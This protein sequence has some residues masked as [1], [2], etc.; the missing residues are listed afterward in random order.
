M[1]RTNKSVGIPDA[2]PFLD[3]HER[4]RMQFGS[5][6]TSDFPVILSMMAM[7]Q[8]LLYRPCVRLRNCLGPLQI[9]R[10]FPWVQSASLRKRRALVTT[11]TELKLI[12][13]AAI[14]GL[15]NRPMNG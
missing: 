12:A 3:L 9:Q 8:F 7:F 10:R 5:S 4:V 11:D 6:L 15:S 1:Q 2:E 14:M 13:A